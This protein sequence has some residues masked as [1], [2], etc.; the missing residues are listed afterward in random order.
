VNTIASQTSA[1]NQH[2]TRFWDS[3]W[4]KAFF[5]LI[6]LGAAF[7]VMG[8]FMQSVADRAVESKTAPLKEQLD[9]LER[10]VGGQSEKLDGLSEKVA[11]IGTDIAVIK[12][13]VVKSA[14]SKA[15]EQK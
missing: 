15:V 6:A 4:T 12:A 11:A 8:S 2:R 10:K 14:D 5:M 13:T 7:G 3:D 1:P 9:R